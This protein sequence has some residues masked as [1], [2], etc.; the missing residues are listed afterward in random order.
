VRGDVEVPHAASV[1][2]EDD[3]HEQDLEAHRGYSE[4]VD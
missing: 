2:G 4:E 1:V 3:Q